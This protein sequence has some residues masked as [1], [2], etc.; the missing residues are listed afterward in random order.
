MVKQMINAGELREDIRS[1]MGEIPIMEKYRISPGEFMDI[2]ETLK[3]VDSN[4]LEIIEAR[5]NELRKNCDPSEMRSVPRNY[6]VFP[7]TVHDAHDP[8]VWGLV[9]DIT[10]SGLQVEGIRAY[11][12]EKRSLIFRCEDLSSET[13]IAFEALCRWAKRGH[14][15]DKDV[16][17]FEITSISDSSLAGLRNLM[18]YLSLG[19]QP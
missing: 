17:G 6:M 16:A 1:G 4:D 14:G 13:E 8:S 3:E 15:G 12:N 2:L 9:N 11:V 18:R 7:A 5:L 10:A 19:E